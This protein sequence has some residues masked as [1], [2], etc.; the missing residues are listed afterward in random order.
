MPALTES[1]TA[2]EPLEERR[3]VL[4]DTLQLHLRAMQQLVTVLAIPFEAVE[5]AFGSRHLHYHADSSRLQPLRRVPH[6]FRQK[7]NLA[8][9]DRNLDRRFAGR[10]HDTEKNVAFELPYTSL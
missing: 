7:K 2:V 4:N 9:L 8:L 10:R 3:Q 5:S 6:V 1:F